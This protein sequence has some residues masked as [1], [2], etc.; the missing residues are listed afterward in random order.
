VNARYFFAA[1]ATLQMAQSAHSAPTP[2]VTVIWSSA[3]STL[4]TVPTLQVVVNP[5]LRPNSAIHDAAFKALE[6]LSADYVRY[7]P[8]SPYPR[9]AVAEL[10]APR[11]GKSSWDFSLID[12]TLLDFLH[13]TAGHP[14]II[15]FST[16]PAWMFRSEQPIS[17][18]K[19][20]DQPDW[21]YY[22]F[23]DAGLIDP[24]GRQAGE[25][26]ARLISWYTQG[27]FIDENGVR[28]HSD[29]HFRLPWWEVL[30]EPEYEQRLTPQQYT[31]LYDSITSAIRKVSP[32]TRFV[33]LASAL[34]TPD[35]LEYFL[36]ARNH[37]PP[38]APDMISYHF[39][40]HP[41][42]AE[43][44]DQW[45]YSFFK[46]ADDFVATVENI[47]RIRER[48]S[49]G[50]RTA[51]DEIGSILPNDAATAAPAP[52]PAIYWNLSGATYAYLYVRLSALGID[53]LGESQ[54]VGFPTQFPDVSMIDWNNGKPNAR[55]WVV[56]LI[57]DNLAPGNLLCDTRTEEGAAPGEII[58]Q[59]FRSANSVR[60]ILLVNKRNHP[61]HVSLPPE[62]V[63]ASLQLVDERSGENPPR[64][65][66]INTAQL[67][68]PAFAVAVVTL[69]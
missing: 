29:Y 14:V 39:Y 32:D 9:L 18:L 27:G 16:L 5:M 23:K 51:I 17:Y 13:A 30:N 69:H 53:A 22:G 15:D 47:E 10:D 4:K 36:D 45:Q 12:P 19:D 20:P 65:L 38:V 35:R 28:H 62:S 56:K 1:L 54:L 52:I 57:R 50:T 42:L 63:G 58:A 31:R 40:V 41:G 43:T 34:P 46:Q 7:V 59:G 24:T 33:G 8:W 44:I 26:F 60:R 37:D 64:K 2:R 67:W 48:L 6:N 25:Y 3:R 11:D 66:H 55:Y 61:M 68:L 49:P 21:Q